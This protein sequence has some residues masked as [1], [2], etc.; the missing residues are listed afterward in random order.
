VSVCVCACARMCV[1]A[2]MC[3]RAYF[4]HSVCMHTVAAELLPQA[5]AVIGLS[6]PPSHLAQ[7]LYGA[8]A[9]DCPHTFEDS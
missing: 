6:P 8:C 4:C 5:T 2:L 9:G 7:Q 1:R 3:V